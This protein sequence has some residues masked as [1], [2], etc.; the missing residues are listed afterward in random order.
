MIKYALKLVLTTL[1]ALWNTGPQSWYGLTYVGFYLHTH[2]WRAKDFQ[3]VLYGIHGH[4]SEQVGHQDRHRIEEPLQL[5]KRN[6]A[7]LIALVKSV[8]YLRKPP[9]SGRKNNKINQKTTTMISIITR[10]P[11]IVQMGLCTFYFTYFFRKRL[12]TE[13]MSFMIAFWK[14]VSSMTSPHVS[15]ASALMRRILL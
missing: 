4:F 12:L 9:R 13:S 2:I 10:V 3:I 5:S 15:N 7:T 1:R 11:L 14:E 6:E 8:L